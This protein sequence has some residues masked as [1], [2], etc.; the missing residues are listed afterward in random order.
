MYAIWDRERKAFLNADGV[1]YTAPEK[2]VLNDL[3]DVALFTKGEYIR[4]VLPYPQQWRY[5]APRIKWR[6]IE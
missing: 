5:V 4:N 6:M 2:G 3:Y 1:T